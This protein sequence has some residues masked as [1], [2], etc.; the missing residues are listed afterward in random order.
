LTWVS[1]P[2]SAVTPTR[3]GNVDGRSIFVVDDRLP[4]HELA[5]LDAALRHGRYRRTE[6]ARED[7]AAFKHWVIELDP[8][9]LG[10][11]SLVE[12][13]AASVEQLF[14][15][16]YQL[17]R[18]YCNVAFF[19]DQLMTHTDCRPGDSIVTAL[20]YVA[21]AWDVEWGGETLFFDDSKD[22]AFVV[23]PR[24]GRLVLFD[25]AILHAGR[26]P[27]RICH[28]PRFTLALKFVRPP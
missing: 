10:A 27:N 22:A 7:T 3:T 13:T 17:F 24:P 28:E 8:N 4:S 12:T 25:G 26:P 14:G 15:S 6:V 1:V 16:G 18:S 9:A 11:P 5:I 2:S 21:S 19:G 23:A 20:W